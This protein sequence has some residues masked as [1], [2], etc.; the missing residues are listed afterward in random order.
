[1]E[2]RVLGKLEV[3]RDGTTVDLGAFRQRALFGLL[4]TA[5]NSVWSTDQIIDGLWGE[6]AAGDKQNALWVYVSGL[7]KALEP[8]REKRTDG[9]ILLTRAP[10]YLVQIDPEALDSVR[11]ERLVA[12]G[13]SLLDTDPPAASLVLSE[14][15]AMWRGQPFEDFTY[16]SFAQAEIARLNELRIEAVGARID[17]DLACGR[18]RE[19]VSELESLVRQH[20]L[21][22]ELTGQWMLAL[23]RSGRQADALRAFDALKSRLVEELGVDPSAEVR[24]LRDRMLDGDE[25]LGAQRSADMS[26]GAS[27]GLAV[28]GY[29]LR[30]QIG[31]GDFGVAYRAYQ[32]AVGREVAIKIIRSELA[33]D[34]SFIRRFEA[35]AR[36]V[37]QLEH[38]HIVPLYD[39]WREPDAAYLV[40][41][42]MTGGTL[43]DALD[44]GALTP[45]HASSVADQLAGALHAAHRSGVVHRDVKPSNVLIDKDGN[46]YLSD[47]GIAIG[48]G[49]EVALDGSIPMSVTVPYASPEQL[50]GGTA[51]A[52]SDVFSLGVVIAQAL[53]GMNGDVD[54]IRGALPTPARPVIDRAT[55]TD[56]DE[57]GDAISFAQD[58]QLALAGRESA[59]VIDT[60]AELANP[61][62]GLR[63][64]SGTD[65]GE[66]FGRD[67]V[68]DRLVAQLGSPGLRGRFVAV[69]GPSGAGKSSVVK[70]GLLPALRGG[71]LP[72]SEHWFVVEMTPAPHPFES[73]EDALLGVAVNPP[74]SL[75]EL[76]VRGESGL[77]E[78]VRA[79]LPADGSQI[80]LVIDQFEELF[81]QVAPSTAKR[82]LDA[83]AFAVNAEHSRLKLVLTLRADFYDRP[84]SHNGLG[85]LLREGTQVITPMNPEQLE[86]AITGP[87]RPL[88]VTFDAA[89]VAELVR[90]VVDRTGALP[91]LQYALT[92]LFERRQGARITA[93]A[94]HDLGG[95]SGA[96][97]QRADGLLAGFDVPAKEA[98][99]QVFLRLVTLGDGEG[100]S[101][102]RRRVRQ[103]ELDELGLDRNDLRIVLETFGRH[104]LLSFDRDA[105]TRGPTVEISHEA[106]LSE[107]TSLRDWIEAARD[108]VRNQRRIASAMLEWKLSEESDG[109]LLRGGRLDQLDG[110]SRSANIALSVA[111]QRFVDLSRA[112][113]DR[114]A[115]EDQAREHRIVEA[116]REVNA[117]R[118]QLVVAGVLGVIVA[119]L[120]IFG[121]TQW[122]VASNARDEASDARL[123][124]EAAR[125]AS[126]RLVVSEQFRI[127]SDSA[128]TGDSEL[129]LLFAVEAV[130]STNDLGYATEEAID[131]LHWALQERGV[132]YPV[133][134]DAVVTIRSGPT[135]LTGV[136]PLPPAELVALAEGSTDRR[137]TEGEC[138]LGSEF[139]CPEP[140][141]IDVDLPLRFGLDEY[142]VN[143]PEVLPGVPAFGDGELAGTRVTLA[144]ASTV[145]R[146]EGIRAELDRFTELT[147]IEVELVSN[148]DFDITRLLATGGLVSAPDVIGFFSAPPPWA[149]DRVVDLSTYLDEDA[150]RADFGDYLVDATTS[151][152]GELQSVI[153]NTSPAGLVFYP[154]QRFD[155][156][157][158]TV[159]TTW[160]ELVAL[161]SQM[162]DDG[163]E[164]WCFSWEAGFA[165]GFAGSDFLESLVLRVAGTEVYDGWAS[166]AIGFDDPRI[167]EAAM[168]GEELLFTPGFVSGGSDS[169]SRSPWQYPALRMLDETPLPEDVGPRCWLAHQS[170]QMIDIL[171]PPEDPRSGRLGEDIDYFM[172]PPLVAGDPANISGGTIRAT[173]LTDRPEVRALM[174]YIASPEWGEVW[175]GVDSIGETFFSSNRRFDTFAYVGQ[176]TQ[177]NISVRLRIHEDNRRGLDDGS[178]RVGA[179]DL[180]PLEFSTWTNE[181]VPGPF[182]QGMI[183][184]ADQTKPVDEVFA[185]IQTAREQS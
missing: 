77:D 152:D 58:L 136:F 27:P 87:V 1:M 161:S 59:P 98:A 75:L 107:W 2:F 137:L 35:E 30:E 86:Q 61:Y 120:A 22:E 37:A 80:L 53:T 100:Q 170:A 13:R 149:A 162:V 4:L 6:E 103:S 9:S 156:A 114:A 57:R 41:R 119:G 172:L 24:R 40:M 46:A 163:N 99:R 55:A 12:E 157:G 173:T 85:E 134:A 25:S 167:V 43:A 66:F 69:V 108:D 67:R 122:V 168:L 181:Y 180:M 91:L 68:V 111:E 32:P 166:G 23:Y 34:P 115:D 21:R 176:R 177:P 93:A 112:A 116:E 83:L 154:K 18:S 124:A 70:A 142:V 153:M 54:Q 139:G 159:P 3:E 129:A 65:V 39:F 151:D 165:S 92:E 101:D 48:T 26:A 17:A 148:F 140:G 19:L 81:S 20:P 171:G 184:W 132:P 147:G 78:A 33:N 72:G 141:P 8:D 133:G 74:A 60:G 135:G 110:W 131:S 49:D 123:E 185:D 7:R 174:A 16:E 88:G 160:D 144:V 95:L 113:R 45:V 102:T 117:R 125:D 146:D 73:L 82:F 10:G 36:L 62:K 38:P 64:F 71:A 50:D 127:A 155:E 104:R 121:I 158:Y 94:Y 179:S 128:L 89:V 5:P 42:L 126:N 150:L 76:L 175:A 14:A 182:W 130:R 164:P 44:D 138:L 96:L 51:V 79:V 63:P 31:A 28:R 15:L 97:V 105:V 90:E 145:G 118:R 178:W 84:L 52:S 143:I 169:I 109:Y 29:E 106:L 183:D 11:F 56:A 47:F